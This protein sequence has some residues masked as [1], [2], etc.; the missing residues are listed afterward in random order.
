VPGEFNV[1]QSTKD[2]PRA[3]LINYT[4]GLPIHSYE[5][6]RFRRAQPHWFFGALGDKIF[7]FHRSSRTPDPSAN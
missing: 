5:N 2:V 6:Y 1:T 3:A 4:F 7:I